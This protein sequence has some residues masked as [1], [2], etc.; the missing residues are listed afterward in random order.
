MKVILAADLKDGNVVHGSSGNRNEYNP[1][2]WGLSPSA[3]PLSYVKVMSPKYLY[4]ADLD[5]IEMCGDHT[6]TILRIKDSV[7]ELY[8]D[9]GCSIPEE[10]LPKPVIN[11]VGTETIDC[12]L[13]EFKGGFLSV[14]VKDGK[15]IPNG[16]D[17]VKFI[18]RL[19]EYSFDGV[20]LLNIS[21]VGTGCGIDVN[22]I[23]KIRSVTKKTLFYGGGVSSE[24]DLDVLLKEGIDGVIISTAVHKGLI[25]LKIIQ[26]GE[27]C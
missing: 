20:I 3:E 15:V 24:K 7:T 17:P 12:P 11:I 22:F 10:Y 8:V 19:D 6:E 2:T 1:L 9:R 26:E 13:N 25:P 23:R 5:R 21:S 18:S 4:I 27:Y 14:D 16:E